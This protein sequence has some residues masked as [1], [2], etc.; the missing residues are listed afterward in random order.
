M[1]LSIITTTYNSEKT[2]TELG[3]KIRANDPYYFTTNMIKDMTNALEDN[4]LLT[5]LINNSNEIE[6]GKI[7]ELLEK[8]LEELTYAEKEENEPIF[9]QN[10]KKLEYHSIDKE[11]EKEDIDEKEDAEDENSD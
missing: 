5:N 6:T 3:D 11:D 2:I 4:K 7:R 1:K 10:D 8:F 9:P